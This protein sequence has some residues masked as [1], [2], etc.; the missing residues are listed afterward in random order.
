[1]ALFCHTAASAV[2][3]GLHAFL[4]SPCPSGSCI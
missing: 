3:S 1:M 2:L 4:Q